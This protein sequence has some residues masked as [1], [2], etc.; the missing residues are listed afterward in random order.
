M[1][2]IMRV[3]TSNGKV[4]DSIVEDYNDEEIIAQKKFIE[5]LPDMK[6]MEFSTKSGTVYFPKG[7]LDNSVVEF[8][9]FD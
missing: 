8:I 6:Y 7:T 9:R 2:M 4:C 5:Q 3:T 1:K